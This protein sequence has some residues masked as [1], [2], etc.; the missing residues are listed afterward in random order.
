[1]NFCTRYGSFWDYCPNVEGKNSSFGGKKA[2][3]SCMLY[4]V[5]LLIW[6][7]PCVYCVYQAMRETIYKVFE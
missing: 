1:M 6:S 7:Y 3:M 5:E 2:L 4:V